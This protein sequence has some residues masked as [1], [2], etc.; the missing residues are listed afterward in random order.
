MSAEFI[1]AV[2]KVK[3]SQSYIIKENQRTK[4][5]ILMLCWSRMYWLTVPHLFLPYVYLT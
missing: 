5:I 2:S 3:D 1:G 4:N